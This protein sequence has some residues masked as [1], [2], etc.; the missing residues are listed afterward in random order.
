ME[1][2][3]DPLIAEDAARHGSRRGS[4]AAAQKKVLLA[5]V[6]FFVW[7]G[8]VGGGFYIGKQYLDESL[9][10]IQQTNAMNIQELNER[11]DSMATQMQDLQGILSTT[12]QTLSSSGNIQRDLNAK[13]EL[14]DS[15]LQSLMQS[16]NILKEAPDAPH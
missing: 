2:R 7:A 8:L 14:L 11:L 5:M 6:A 3:K 9:R 15:Q 12:D 4:R 1:K 10:T 13:I 16:L